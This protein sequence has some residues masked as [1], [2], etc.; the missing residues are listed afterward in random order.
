MNKITIET[1]LSKMGLQYNS[2]FQHGYWPSCN[3]CQL[4]RKLSDSRVEFST[5][6]EEQLSNM[7]KLLSIGWD[8]NHALILFTKSSLY[9]DM[10]VAIVGKY[11]P[12]GSENYQTDLYTYTC[13]VEEFKFCDK[14]SNE[15]TS[16]KI[17][18]MLNMGLNYRDIMSLFDDII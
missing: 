14:F 6:S 1:E 2:V 17:M 13:Y 3:C 11:S 18:D 7:A 10:L 4:T 15:C 12:D 5:C 16:Q 9:I 8:F